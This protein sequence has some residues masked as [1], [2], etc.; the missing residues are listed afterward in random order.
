MR[1]EHE[2]RLNRGHIKD[3][4]LWVIL[5]FYWAGVYLLVAIGTL[6]PFIL[7]YVVAGALWLSFQAVRFIAEKLE[8]GL[9]VRK[10]F[11]PAHWSVT[12]R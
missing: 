8:R 2:C 6:I 10:C 1:D 4:N 12:H 11:Q 5:M 7:L 3:P 9:T